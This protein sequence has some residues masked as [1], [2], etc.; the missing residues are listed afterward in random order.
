MPPLL[1]ITSRAASFAA[2][3]AVSR[4]LP[5]SIALLFALAAGS[6]CEA[7]PV[8]V[9]SASELEPRHAVVAGGTEDI[10]ALVDA[11]FAAWTAKDADAF[12]ATYA[13]DARFFDPIGGVLEGRE[14]IRAE[15][16]F[17]FAGPFAATTE[18]QEVADIRFLTGTIV[19]VY[20]NAALAGFT[21]PAPTEPGVLRTTKTWVV[22]KRAGAWQIM[23]QHMAPVAPTS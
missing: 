1:L 13:S 10:Q 23:T 4:L 14:A 11:Q 2:G 21:G 8:G 20:L 17:L 5:T 19:V 22:V 18:T 16:A 6:A 3:P 15:L 12:A 9:G 7:D